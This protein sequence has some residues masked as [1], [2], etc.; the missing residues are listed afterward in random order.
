MAAQLKRQDD[1]VLYLYGISE[2]RSAT[3]PEEI[4]VAL[5]RIEPV[6][7]DGVI[8]W[9]SWVAGIDFEQNLARNME[10]LDWLAEASVA[11]QRAVSAIARETEILPARFG[12]VFRSETSLRQH[13][14]GRARFLKRDFERVRGA[15][16]WGVKVFGVPLNPPAVPKVRTGKDYLKA[17][18]A[19]LPK[20]REPL[21]ANGDLAKFQQALKRIA[22]ETAAVGNISSGQRGLAFQTSLLVKRVHRKKLESVLKKFSETWES[23][24]RI[25]CT[26]PWPPYSFVSGPE[27]EKSK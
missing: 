8:C 12:T 4:G 5:S 24:R 19:L 7:C 25:E 18:A 6:D 13:V 23:R 1:R 11:H 15:D 2:S 3:A 27:G 20:K 21:H 14:R 26:G 17:K 10:N 22:S 16:E 9:V